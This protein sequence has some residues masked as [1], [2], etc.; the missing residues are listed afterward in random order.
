M[1]ITS[2]LSKEKSR[3]IKENGEIYHAQELAKLT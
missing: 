2:S 3:K 1:T